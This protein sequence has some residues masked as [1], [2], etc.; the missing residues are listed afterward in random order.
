MMQDPYVAHEHSRNARAMLD[1]VWFSGVGKFVDTTRVR[2]VILLKRDKDDSEI[3]RRLDGEEA[4]HYLTTQPEQFLDPYL[5][6]KTQEKVEI[7]QDFFRR[8]FG[9]A[10]CCLVNTVEPV[11]TVQNRIREIVKKPNTTIF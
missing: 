7:R 9:F 8:L 10:P 2:K 1:P 5:I 11:D 3:V 4:V 6:V